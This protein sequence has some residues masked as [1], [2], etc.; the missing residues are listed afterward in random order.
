MAAYQE[1][2]TV[3][4]T[5][6]LKRLAL[7]E[8][9]TARPV[10]EI[11]A[12]ETLLQNFGQKLASFIARDGRIH[13]DYNL[14]G[15]KTGRFTCSNPNLQQLPSARAPDVRKCIT[16]EPGNVLIGCD[17]N[18]IEMRA[19]AH[20]SGDPVLTRVYAEGRDL[21]SETAARIA[22]L[23]VDRV[24]KDQR[25]AAKAV[26]FGS[27]YGIGPAA[28]AE[29]C[30]DSYGIVMTKAE[31]KRA[32]D[33]FFD[34]YSTLRDWR[35][36]NHRHCKALGLVRIGCGRV[37]EADWEPY[38]LR[39]PQHCNLPIQGICADAMLRA[40][41]LVFRRLRGLR[42]GLVASVHDELLIEAA[43]RDAEKARAIL[44]ETMIEAFTMTFPGAPTTGVISCGVGVNWLE[45]K[46]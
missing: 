40:I 8:V 45:A 15:S 17:W 46:G 16:A 5:T 3:D 18:Q 27:I 9:P 26:N 43:E 33:R 34:T 32:L 4:Q 38:G 29:D 35:W 21:H 31:A 23:P 41:T 11:L 36:E 14:A 13:A 30:F 20:I 7:S 24:T 39:F 2:R 28:L 10:L 37:V 25:N 42:A 19:A 22:A 12:K 6:Y 44:E 1:R